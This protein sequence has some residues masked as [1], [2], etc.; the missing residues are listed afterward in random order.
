MEED[1][2]EVLRFVKDN[3][4]AIPFTVE[5]LSKEMMA[6]PLSGLARRNLDVNILADYVKYLV[7]K[8]YIRLEHETDE[9]AVYKVTPS[10]KIFISSGG[11]V[12][13]RD[14]ENGFRQSTLDAN[15][16]VISTNKS[17]RKTNQYQII[18]LVFSSITAL[19]ALYMQYASLKRDSEFNEKLELVNFRLDSINVQL[20]SVKKKRINHDTSVE[21]V[22]VTQTKKET[23]SK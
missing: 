7:G 2:D 23:L 13:Q 16:S 18:A 1:L 15:S 22:I 5:E 4:S 14:I 10:G 12:R 11:F 8:G 21:K 20:D 9:G 6:K 17:V 3:F 19:F